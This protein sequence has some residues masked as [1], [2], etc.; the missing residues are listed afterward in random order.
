MNNALDNIGNWLK[1]NKLALIV[2][3]SKLILFNIKKNRKSISDTNISVYIDSDELEHKETAKY[4][5]VF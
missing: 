4:L 2:K 5:G 3:K 1:A